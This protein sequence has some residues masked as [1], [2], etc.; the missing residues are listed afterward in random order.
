MNAAAKTVLALAA[1]A[2]VAVVASSGD[3]SSSSSTAEVV[4][5]T[6][7]RRT[8][9]IRRHGSQGF[10]YAVDGT[11]ISAAATL[12]DAFEDVLGSLGESSEKDDLVRFQLIDRARSVVVQ[13]A[14]NG[15][16]WTVY[17]GAIVDT[18]GLGLT[19]GAALIAALDELGDV[20]DEM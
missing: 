3:E 13:H 10:A 9:S 1:V 11:E 8:F 18:D 5:G 4:T 16:T 12:R 2:A 15:W 6:Y 14:A 19:R 7:G 20:L 17:R